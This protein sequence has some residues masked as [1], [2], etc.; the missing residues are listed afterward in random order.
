MAGNGGPGK[1]GPRGTLSRSDNIRKRASK[2]SGQGAEDASPSVSI[3]SFFNK[4]PP[5]AVPCP[6]C[7]QTVSRF[8]INQHIDEVCPQN[9]GAD[10]D[11]ILVEPASGAGTSGGDWPS[12]SSPDSAKDFSAPETN[13]APPEGCSLKRKLGVGEQSSPYFKRGN[14]WRGSDAEPTVGAVKNISLGSLASKLSRRRCAQGG[15]AGHKCAENCLTPGTGDSAGEHHLGDATPEVVSQKENSFPF[16]RSKGQH[17]PNGTLTS[18]TGTPGRAGDCDPEA[19]RVGSEDSTRVLTPWGDLDRNDLALP[20]GGGGER[21]KS[22]TDPVPNPGQRAACSATHGEAGSRGLSSGERVLSAPAKP[23]PFRRNQKSSFRRGDTKQYPTED[24]PDF[25]NETAGGHTRPSERLTSRNTSVTVSGTLPDPSGSAADSGG[26]PYYLRNFLTV[27]R[28]VL[29]ESDDVRLFDEHELLLAGQFYALSGGG[30]KLYVRLFQRKL[31]WIKTSKLKYVEIGDD[32]F[33]Y[34]EELVGAGF[35]ESD[36]DLRDLAEVLDLLSAPELKT[37]AQTFH[38]ANPNAQK[39]QLLEGFFK[40][41]K[42]RSIFSSKESGIGSVILKRAKDLA[43]KSIR[44]CKGPRDVFS[45]VLLLFTLT[46]PM[47]EEE[48]GSGGQKALSTLLLVNLGRTAFP[49]YTVKPEHLIFQDREDFLRYATAVHTSNDIAVAMANRDWE[50]AHRLYKAAEDT[51]RTLETHPSLRHHAALPEYLRCFTFGWVYTRIL[52]RG[53]EILQRLRMYEDAVGQLED[54][55]AQDVYCTDSRGRWWDRLALNL[56][57]HLKETEKVRSPSLSL[58]SQ[59]LSQPHLPHRVSVVGRGRETVS[60]CETLNEGRGINPISSSSSLAQVTIKGK[61]CPQTGMGKS[62][63]ITEDPGPEDGGEDN[64]LSVVVCSVEELALAHY[65]QKGF[66]QGIHG[67]GSTF[68]TLYGLLMWDI[69]FMDGIPDVFRNPY[70]SC[71]LDLYTD[72]FYENR[73]EAIEARLQLLHAASPEAL[74]EWI[75]EV[76]NAQ[77]GKATALVSWERFSSLEQA[78]N[79]VCCFGGPFLSGV[80]RRLSRDLRHCRGGLPDLVVW[81][82][83]DR[84][85]KLVEVKGPNDRLSPKQMLWL[86]ELQRLGAAVEVCHVAAI[87][88]KSERLS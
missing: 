15:K 81:R 39:Q 19:V 60:H 67:E 24:C 47:E 71:P 6:L 27:L 46:D 1:K 74:T 86:A 51:W 5:S 54:L 72:S 66:D 58:D 13:T 45:R 79:L 48:A 7:G 25:R 42:Q 83:E 59:E 75:G 22:P 18:V 40:L 82:T 69:V 33:P 37:L 84:Q 4:V 16:P 21:T 49:A 36:S 35:L 88:S 53:V 28:A 29:E 57:Q 43:G 26:H 11:V 68:S 50:E 2:K 65:K 17:S 12:C 62:V 32:L 64:E 63:F 55:L 30:Q 61:L 44:L 8:Q 80:C 14:S 87:G 23:T 77:K 73:K 20:P 70:Q 10:D 3:A 9:R 41:A 31:S 56:H 76:W 34:I 78:Q 38:L 85:F 52:S